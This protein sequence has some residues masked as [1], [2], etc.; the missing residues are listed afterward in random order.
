MQVR[1]CGPR[2]S[3]PSPGRDMVRYGGNTSCVEVRCGQQR[4]ILDA[5]TGIRKLGDSLI[6]EGPVDSFT[7]TRAGAAWSTTRSSPTLAEGVYTATATQT[8]A[9]GKADGRLHPA[10]APYRHAHR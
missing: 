6:A 1:V 9:A 7:V 4:I 8:D 2:G 10:A 5:G 3:L